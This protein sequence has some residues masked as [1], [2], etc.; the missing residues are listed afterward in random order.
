MSSF[1]LNNSE[2][3]EWLTSL[4]SN[5]TGGGNK[6]KGGKKGKTKKISNRI[7][8]EEIVEA[9]EVEVDIEVLNDEMAD[10]AVARD[11]QIALDRDLYH[12]AH[13]YLIQ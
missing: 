8:K 7:G 10:M 6:K 2:E 11:L 5:S 3:D 9:E 1:D 12:N 4:S 13:Q